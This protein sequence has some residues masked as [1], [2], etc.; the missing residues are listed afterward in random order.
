MSLKPINLNNHLVLGAAGNSKSINR[1]YLE[2]YYTELPYKLGGGSPF[3]VQALAAV[4][5]AISNNANFGLYTD[6]NTAI[7]NNGVGSGSFLAINGTASNTNIRKNSIK[8]G[9]THRVTVS[10]TAGVERSTKDLVVKALHVSDTSPLVTNDG[11]DVPGLNETLTNGTPIHPNTLLIEYHGT[12]VIT[13]VVDTDKIKIILLN[14]NNNFRI[15]GTNSTESSVSYNTDLGMNLTTTAGDEDQVIIT[16]ISR[17]GSTIWKTEAS[18]EWECMIKVPDITTIGF[19]CGMKLT[20]TNDYTT[21]INQM[22]F[23]YD[24]T[25]VESLTASKLYFIYS[26]SATNDYITQIDKLNSNDEITTEMIFNFKIR[27]NYNRQVS[28]FIN[29]VQYPI[30]NTEG[31][32]SIKKSSQTGCT[33]VSTAAMTDDISLYPYIGV[34]TRAN[35]AKT[36]NVLYQKI[37]RLIK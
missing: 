34:I 13:T 33:N 36:I 27:L 16:P 5:T 15:E 24:T 8:I 29:D 10:T 19:W 6:A 37:N 35:A 21:D 4:G 30:S 12:T 11:P 17:W 32:S 26:N 2:D 14:N 20:N 25:A 22:F 9:D 1:Y 3:T 18:I 7:N 31:T 28:I 23:V